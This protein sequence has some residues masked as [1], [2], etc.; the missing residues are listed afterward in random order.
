MLNGLLPKSICE[1]GNRVFLD[2]Y[3]PHS[4]SLGNKVYDLGAGSRPFISLQRKNELAVTVVG[5]DISGEE[6]AAA[7]P[8]VYDQLIV[9][10]L[11][12]FTGNGDG[13]V[14]ICQATLEHVRDGDGAMKAIASCLKSGGRAF[15]FAPC[16]NAVFARLNLIL[17]QTVKKYLLFAFF[18]KK[19]EG[20][21]GFPAF[22]DKCTPAELEH[23]AAENGLDVE[24]RR[25][26]WMSS[27]FTVFTPAFVAW[28]I[29]QGLSTLLLGRNAAE[30]YVYVLRKREKPDPKSH[31][32]ETGAMLRMH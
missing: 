15:I 2:V 26:F 3:I 4:V 24:Q 21:D 22:Y 1:D 6:L 23:L 29:V 11:T 27:Y 32:E 28:R 5:L 7:P 18:P 13:D 31:A 30:T 20:H 14:V 16:R 19:A 8:G 12:N 25:L 9:A 10:D 17:P